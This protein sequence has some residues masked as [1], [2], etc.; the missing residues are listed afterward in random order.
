METKKLLGD[1]VKA[2][3][4]KVDSYPE[5][6]RMGMDTI[7][8]DIPFKLKLAITLSELITF[9]S[10]LRKPIKLHDGTIV[11]TNA[12]V[13]ALSASGTSKDKSLNA[14][15]KSLTYAYTH[16][17]DE[18]K[19]HAKNKA[20][21]LARLE[22]DDESNWPRYYKEPK[23]LQSGLGTVEGLMHHFAEIAENQTGAGSIMSSEIGSELQNNGAMVDIIKT[24]SVA[25]DLGNIPPKIV[26][27]QENQTSAIKGLP[28]NA[29][30]FGS[31]EALLFDNQIKSKFK[32]V[33]NTQLA[34]R[35][36]FSFTPETPEKIKINSIDEL[37]ELREAERKRVA[38]AQESLN[39]MTGDLVEDID[40]SPLE[41]SAEAQRLF[42]VYL[43][44]NSILS[45]EMSNKFPI[46]KLS[47]KHKQWLALKLAGTYAILSKSSEIMEDHYAYAINTVELLSEDLSNFEAE[48]VKEPYEQLVDMCRFKAEDGELFLTLHELRKLSYVVGNGSSKG[49]VE[50]LC[51]MA[52][53]YDETGSY[54]TQDGGILYKELIKT[55][56]VG[57]T[58]KIFETSET[59]DKLKDY[60]ARN[61]SDGYEFFETDFK[62]IENLLQCNAIYSSFAFKDNVRKKENLIGGTKFVV[63]DVD[64]SVLT[65]KEAHLL[66]SEYNHYVVRT[67][68]PDNE[69][70]F[71]VIVEMDAIVDVE[72]R[73]WKPFLQEVAEELGLI[74]DLLPQSQ[75]YLSFADRDIH[76]NLE[77]KQLQSKPLI[78]RAAVRLRD[79]P[80]PPNSLPD[81]EKKA[82]LE[83]PRTTFAFAFE[84]EPGERS[85]KIYRALAYAIDLGA[86]KDYVENLANEINDYL[87][88]SMDEDRLLRTLITPAL[89]R[90]GE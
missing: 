4:E 78:D 15:R 42:D 67:S 64:K 19:E 50:E 41:V 33:F 20:I 72:E 85:N 74:V 76:M 24:I 44:Y 32:L 27:S 69:F 51:T 22:G 25:Y 18:R 55:D 6:V 21:S 8:G 62:D 77:G 45:D 38:K 29:L 68:N 39:V 73:M 16:I 1:F 9:S 2:R 30:F 80:K 43:E 71:R 89:R 88:N 58:Y 12:I 57:V 54:T 56:R 47:R 60:M 40:H 70:K 37:Y 26:K 28:V 5:I 53:S 48:L 23:P 81:K 10:H 31:Q 35:S 65:D 13:F 63:L 79:K 3:T 46:S 36:L 11:P 14:V 75:I 59:G 66:L 90:M 82:K 34:R 61:S 84:C 17:E 49:K 86:E 83:D 7:Q 52:N 87:T